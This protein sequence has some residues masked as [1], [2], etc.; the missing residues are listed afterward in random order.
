M[1]LGGGGVLCGVGS[2][3]ARVH[4]AV[5]APGEGH[6]VQRHLEA[7]V[8]GRLHASARYDATAW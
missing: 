3:G 7:E 5:R 2:R 4:A 6:N 1:D 8:S